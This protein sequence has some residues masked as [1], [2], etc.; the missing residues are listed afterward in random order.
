MQV[1]LLEMKSTG[2]S[3]IKLVTFCAMVSNTQVASLL[4]AEKNSIIQLE[5]SD[6]SNNN[7]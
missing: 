1:Q 6:E 7:N 2:D 4:A 5:I 3:G